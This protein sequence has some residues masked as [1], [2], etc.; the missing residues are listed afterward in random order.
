MKTKQLIL[1]ALALTLPLAGTNAQQWSTNTLPSGL[2]AWWQ[3]EGNM[4]DSAGVHHGSGSA[5]P[6]YGVGRFGQ[7]FQFNGTDQS[8]SVPDVHADLDSWT[9]FTLEAW[10]NLDRTADYSPSAPGRTIFSKVGNVAD[11][12]NYNQGY[13]FS[14][15]DN[16]TKIALA[17]NTNGQAW[18]GFVTV[19]DLGAPLATNTWYHLV[20]TYDQN[21]VKI[22]LNGVPL[23][24]NVIGPV[25]LQNS[26]SS[27]RISKDDNLN[28][29]FAGRIDDARIYNR[30]LSAAEIAYLYAGPPIP[31]VLQLAPA[32]SGTVALQWAATAGLH[33]QLQSVSN[34]PA[35]N[36]LDEGGPFIGTGGVL[37]T[38]LPI[39]PE[40]KKFFR[41]LL[42]GN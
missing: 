1:L 10:M 12:V 19:A 25:T 33:Y 20:G 34:L 6:T 37:T 9:Q 5:S 36:W 26:G 3:A 27:L 11:H 35:A 31:P 17:F 41:L 38:N 23:I 2:I 15:Y 24:T 7:A 21:A 28:C 29:P 14:P 13:Q 16:A 32:A 40:P 39:G 18:P 42:L 4:L 8:V 30:A 22:Y